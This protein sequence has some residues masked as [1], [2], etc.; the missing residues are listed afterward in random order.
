MSAQSLPVTPL[1]D[2]A[3]SYKVTKA[4]Y[5]GFHQDGPRVTGPGGTTISIS[6]GAG[7]TFSVDVSA[8]ATAEAGVIF[9]KASATLGIS[10]SNTWTSNTTYRDSWAI[11]KSY[12]R[13][14]L[15]I[16]NPKYRI[17]ATVTYQSP[18]C[19]TYTRTKNYDGI[20]HDIDFDNGKVS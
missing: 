15:A 3:V 17:T 18:N 13:G 12:S 11:P 4:T 6:R 1:S 2:T 10:V 8:S 14:Y 16:G 9:A 20:T 19:T 5:L 7:T